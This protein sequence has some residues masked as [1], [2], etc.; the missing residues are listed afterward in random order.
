MNSVDPKEKDYADGKH[1]SSS[2]R[3]LWYLATCQ[4]CYLEMEV[5]R[6]QNTEWCETKGCWAWVIGG[7]DLPESNETFSY[8]CRCFRQQ[9]MLRFI[10]GHQFKSYQENV[11]R[12]SGTHSTHCNCW[13]WIESGTNKWLGG[14]VGP[15]CASLPACSI[16]QITV[17]TITEWERIVSGLGFSSSVGESIWLHIW[18]A[19]TIGK[20]EIRKTRPIV[21]GG[22]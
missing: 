2:Q 12:K 6:W 5:N 11:G 3:F 19:R 17:A 8:S 1:K 18:R 9:P 16:S 4:R 22:S 20:G 14:P 15:I 13:E 10:D 21:L 7:A